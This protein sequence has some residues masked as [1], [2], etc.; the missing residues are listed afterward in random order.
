MGYPLGSNLT[1]FFYLAYYFFLDLIQ[2]KGSSSYISDEKLVSI[3]IKATDYVLTGHPCYQ[4]KN[5]FCL[6][7]ILE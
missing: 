6:N 2:Y 1:L 4:S 7:K 3:R 5:A